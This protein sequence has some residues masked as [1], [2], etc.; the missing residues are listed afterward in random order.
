[1][2]NIGEEYLVK[3]I[4]GLDETRHHLKNLGFVPG[5]EVSVISIICGN[6]IVQVKD[7]RI[8]ISKEL[9]GKIFI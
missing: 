7:A 3:K 6:I 4:G 2:A 1:M 8:A 5:T 9:A